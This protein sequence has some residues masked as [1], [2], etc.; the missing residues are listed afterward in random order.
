MVR[1]FEPSPIHNN[2]IAHK[3]DEYLSHNFV[4][5]VLY[6]SFIISDQFIYLLDNGAIQPVTFLDYPPFYLVFPKSI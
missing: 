1:Y 3:M 5:Q 4:E 2:V 6:I